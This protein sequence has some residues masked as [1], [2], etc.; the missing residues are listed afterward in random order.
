MSYIIA[1][2]Y[3]PGSN[4]E[5][6][7][8]ARIREF[9]MEP[10]P[11]YFHMGHKD[12]DM[13]ASQL[14]KADGAVLPGGFPYED[15][16]GFGKVPAAIKPFAA[17]LR[18]LAG[19]GKP[20]LAF[21]SGNQIAH[22]MGLAF[23]GNGYEIEMLPNIEDKG[24]ELVG[25]GIR[26]RIV[27]TKLSVDPQRTA[28][29]RLYDEGEVLPTIMDH[30]GGRF[31]TTHETLQ[32]LAGQGMVVSR[33]CDSN[34]KVVD[35]FPI[36]PNGSML[37]IEGITNRRGNVFLQMCHS[38]RKLNALEQSRANLVFASM[39]DFLDKGCPEGSVFAGPQDIPILLKDYGYLSEAL[40]PA[41]TLELYV[42]MLTDDNER[43]TAQLFLGFPLERRRLLR[44]EVA[45][46]YAPAE[47]QQEIV[48]RIAALDLL[49]GVILK[50]DLPTIVAPGQ[51]PLCYEVTERD[52]R[53]LVR[54][55]VPHAEIVEGYPVRYEQVG[56]PNP[57]GYALRRKLWKDPKLRRLVSKVHT[58]ASWF[59][60]NEGLKQR[61]LEE[62][63][64]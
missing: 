6:D 12:L 29:T 39:K 5:V 7:A 11:L 2:P 57:G 26:D 14:L 43:N 22:A 9:G 17:A 24:G 19:K 20:I 35:N 37:N 59:F 40:D 34:G 30:G 10:L 25:K 48:E 38:E 55:F 42:K 45:E 61:A 8:L 3:F 27:N 54:G 56:L 50:K 51:T 21:C 28:F 60:Q 36:N 64:G 62:L 13:N 44:I 16:L 63:L 58:G 4:G 41:R 18:E 1:V 23:S 15:R 33:Y 49:R 53:T 47:V 46:V 32:Y 52:E 31:W